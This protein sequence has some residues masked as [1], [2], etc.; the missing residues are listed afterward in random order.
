MMTI[1][2]LLARRIAGQQLA[3]TKFKKPEQLVAWL[4][5]VQSQDFA[6]AKWAIG[7]RIPGLKDTDVEKAFNAGKILRTHV[8]RPTWH[9]VSPA[10]IRWMQELTS[11]RVHAVSAYMY[12]QGSLDT[13][14]FNRSNDIIA[15]ALEGGNFLTRTELQALLAKK[16]IVASGHNL[17]Y[18]MMYAELEGLICSGPRRGKQFTYALLSERAPE[19]RSLPREEALATLAARYFTGRSPASAAD[20]SWWSGLTSKETKSAIAG[21]G[22]TFSTEKIDGKEYIVNTKMPPAK[23]LPTFLLPDYDEYGIAYKD[24]SALRSE[25]PPKGAST[26]SHWLI[27]DGKIEGTWKREEKSKSITVKTFPFAP[28]TKP[29]QKAVNNAVNAYLDFQS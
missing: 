7:L 12:R 18:L 23:T 28:L 11:S 22:K 19:A 21:L 9:F 3:G 8:L 25:Y 26:Y 2:E 20:F 5:A 16:K 10:D 17:G 6:M 1:T 15:K 24:R 14:T 29:R 13:A 27:V 4:G